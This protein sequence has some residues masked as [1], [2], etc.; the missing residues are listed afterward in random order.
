ME[1]RHSLEIEVAFGFEDLK[2]KKKIATII[3]QHKI[4]E[5]KIFFFFSIKSTCDVMD[6]K[7]HYTP[8][9]FKF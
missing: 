2:K 5:F 6:L 7:C 1:C 8:T 9:Y 3:Q 4:F